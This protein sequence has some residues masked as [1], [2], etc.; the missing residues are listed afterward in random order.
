MVMPLTEAVVEVMLVDM[1]S[2]V[3]GYEKGEVLKGRASLDRVC[4]K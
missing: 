4:R 2:G 1:L 3:R